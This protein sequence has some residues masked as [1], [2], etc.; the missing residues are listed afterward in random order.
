MRVATLKGCLE[1]AEQAGLRFASYYRDT[2][3]GD[4]DCEGFHACDGVE[5]H[6]PGGYLEDSM[7][8]YYRIGKGKSFL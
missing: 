8:I 4:F 1:L 7:N 2:E 3:S 6:H 5:E